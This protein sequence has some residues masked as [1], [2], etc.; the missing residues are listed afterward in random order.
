MRATIF[1]MPRFADQRRISCRQQKYQLQVEGVSVV[2][3]KNYVLQ[4]FAT[5]PV[6]SQMI[7]CRSKENQLQVEGVSVAGASNKKCWMR[8]FA[9]G[10]VE[11][12]KLFMVK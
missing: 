10:Q 5:D 2:G 3:K 12:A 7:S 6:D 1:G 11:K 8:R 9:D 4:F